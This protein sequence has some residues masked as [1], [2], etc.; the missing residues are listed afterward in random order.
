MKIKVITAY[1]A[2]SYTECVEEF[3][4]LISEYDDKD[5]K[6]IGMNYDYRIW[7]LVVVKE[8]K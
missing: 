7:A 2:N 4:K 1:H 6:S 8:D 5:I 3:N